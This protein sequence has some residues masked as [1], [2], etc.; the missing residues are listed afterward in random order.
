MKTPFPQIRRALCKA[1]VFALMLVGCQANAQI[2]YQTDFNGT[3]GAFPGVGTTYQDWRV[4]SSASPTSTLSGDG[5]LQFTNPSNAASSGQFV[6]AYWV[7]GAGAVND[8]KVSDGKVSD[9]KITTTVQFASNTNQSMGVL[10]RVQN[11][12][13]PGTP[14]GYF[15]G[16]L[17]YDPDK[18]GTSKTYLVICKDIVNA[19]VS[20]YILASVP[21]SL[22]AGNYYQLSFEFMGSA[23]TATLFDQTGATQINTV[24]TTDASYQIGVTGLRMNFAVKDRVVGFDDYQVQG[25]PEVPVGALLPLGIAILGARALAKK[26]CK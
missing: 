3:A 22:T 8:G 7:G 19:N 10:G 13:V 2:L 24:S 6:S 23:L 12:T 26:Q 20:D 17:R 4:V 5:I 14:L 15:A 18:T 21:L 11:P 1:G 9:G 16:I 25:I